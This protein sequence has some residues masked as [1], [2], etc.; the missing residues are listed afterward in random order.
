MGV[1]T[2]MLNSGFFVLLFDATTVSSE[3]HKLTNRS[4]FS[5]RKMLN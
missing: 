4:D 2:C 3:A 5:L 1:G